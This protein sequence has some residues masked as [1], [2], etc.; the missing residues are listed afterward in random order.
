MNVHNFLFLYTDGEI[1][2]IT[3]LKFGNKTA[4][5]FFLLFISNQNDWAR[6]G[7]EPGTSRTQSENHA[8]RP[9]SHLLTL[10]G[11][12]CTLAAG[13]FFTQYTMLFHKV[14]LGWLIGGV[15]A[16]GMAK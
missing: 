11:S 7:F 16:I 1:Q 6:P 13:V 2:S 9:T 5:I 10:L 8:P 14:I 4:M 3:V 15:V 12:A